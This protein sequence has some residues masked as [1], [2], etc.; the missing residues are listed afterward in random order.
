MNYFPDDVADFKTDKDFISNKS[1]DIETEYSEVD[2]Y[3]NPVSQDDDLA[4]A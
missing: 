4:I 1:N 2:S 3:R